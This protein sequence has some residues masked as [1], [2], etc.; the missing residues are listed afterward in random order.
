M[1]GPFELLV[2]LL[3]AAFKITGYFFVC[4]IQ[5]VWYAIC[6]KPDKI[7]DAFGYFGRGAIDTIAAA[8]KDGRRH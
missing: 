4:L 3:I 2:G 5:A 8:F 1:P 6:R 7:G